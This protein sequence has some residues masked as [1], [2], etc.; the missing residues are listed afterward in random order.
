VQKLFQLKLKTQQWTFKA[1][2][3]R[4]VPTYVHINIDYGIV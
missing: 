1:F 2:L 4:K 3:I